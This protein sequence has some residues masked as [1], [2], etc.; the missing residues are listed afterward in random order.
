MSRS[1]VGVIWAIVFVTLESIQFVYFGGLFQRMSSFLFGFLVFGI[2]ASTVLVWALFQAREQ[3]A[4]VFAKP[5]PLIGANVCAVFAWAC[6]LSSVQL[7]EPAVAYTV[8]AGF[9]PITAYLAY[10]F[11]VPEGDPMRNRT[12]MFG[13]LLLLAGVVYFAI[14]TVSGQSGFVRGGGSVALMGVLLAII[15]GAMFTW[16]LIFC[17]RMDRNGVG[18]GLVFGIRLPLYVVVAGF[19]ATMGIDH[20]VSLPWSEIGLIVF[21]GLALTI[22]PLYALQ[23]AVATISTLTIGA[24][25]ALGPFLIFGLQMVEDRV[26]YSNATLAGLLLYFSGAVLASL[27][28]VK[29]SPNSS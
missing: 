29:A 24:L 27:G 10:R 1:V 28:A 16:T 7:I 20:K 3:L 21:I 11:G 19:M 26:E 25:T 8:S 12:E 18:P 13:N 4:A 2:I 15:D 23:R 14:I 6:Y 22:P 17:Q 5:G 9:M